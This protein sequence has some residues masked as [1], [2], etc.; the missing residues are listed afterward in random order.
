VLH[1]FFNHTS[2]YYYVVLLPCSRK[3]PVIKNWISSYSS[4]QEELEN[5]GFIAVD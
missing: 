4:I 3:V 2:L 1:N 5:N